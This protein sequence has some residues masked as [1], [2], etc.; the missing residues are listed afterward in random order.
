M[1][2]YAD[3]AATTPVKTEVVDAMMEI[4]K[5]HYGNPSSIHSIGRDARKYLDQSR[6]KV[7]QLLGAKPHEVIFTSG[8][9]ESNNT[10]IKGLVKA[11]E[12]LGH[13][14]ITSK[15][16]HHSVLHVF[17][18][19]EREGYDVTYLDV[20]DTGAVD[21]DQL[22]E[23]I[24]D[25]TILVSIMFVNNEVGTVQNMYDIEDIIA[26]TNALFHVD[27]VQAIGHLEI[28]FHDFKIDTMSVTGHKFGGPKGAGILLVKDHTPLEFNQLGG[29]QTE[30]PS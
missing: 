4:Y 24:T 3:Y 17:E 11:N 23:T 5:E 20:D 2:V 30:P 22:R 18:Q 26:E 12:Q 9:T 1:E 29:K 19:L 25:K 10:A 27:A 6:R 16:E 28:D 21:L 8:A 15:I 13:H 14:I 7:A